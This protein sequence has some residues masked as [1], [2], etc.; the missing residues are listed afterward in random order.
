MILSLLIAKGGAHLKT[1][2]LRPSSWGYTLKG[3][4]GDLPA[5]TS[6]RVGVG[7]GDQSLVIN[8]KQKLAYPKALSF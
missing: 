2:R 1:D 4:H 3:N 7:G 5:A 6:M 8:P